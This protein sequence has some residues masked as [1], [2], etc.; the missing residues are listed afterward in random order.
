MFITVACGAISGFHATQSPLMARC[1]K[2]EKQGHFVF[3]GAMVCE[4]VI[5]LIWAAPDAPCMPLQAALTQDFR[6]LLPTVSPAA[7]Y[8][9]CARRRWAESVS[10]L[11][12][13]ELLHAR[14]LPVTHGFQGSAR[15]VVADWFKIDQKA[16]AS[17]LKL[18]IPLLAA[19]AIIGHLDYTIVWRYFSWTNQTLAMIVLWTRQH[20]PLQ[21]EK[22]YW[23]T[24]VPAT[25]MSAVSMTYFFYAG[26]MPESGHDGG[27]SG[28]NY[29]GGSIPWNLY[30]CN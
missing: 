30:A 19:G 6:R 10:H 2:S 20:V 18:C 13:L 21:R 24:A 16:Y 17:R 29:S 1:M 7:I 25:F 5:A 11:P 28:R 8:D 9:I 12:C 4:G 3:Y 26:R 23:L 15:L 22:N 27:V 14:S